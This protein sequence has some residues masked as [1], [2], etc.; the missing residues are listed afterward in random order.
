MSLYSRFLRTVG[1]RRW[2]AAVASRLAPVLDRWMYRLS[3]RRRVAS[4]NSIPTLF[5]TTIGRHT[6]TS[7]TV[8]I[9]FVVN[10]DSLIV[11]GSNWGKKSHPQWASNLL[12]NPRADVE[13]GGKAWSVTALLVEQPVRAKYWERLDAMW[14]AY[15]AYRKRAQ[16]QVRMFRLTPLVGERT[17][18]GSSVGA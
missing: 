5:L 13:H 7:L 15:A 6:G 17:D 12:V 4:P 3:G 8:P 1:H 16:R 10:G 18:S 11:V 2:F 9:S 14:P